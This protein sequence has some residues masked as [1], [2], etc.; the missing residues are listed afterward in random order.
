MLS[1]D[2]VVHFREDLKPVRICHGFDIGPDEERAV[3][4]NTMLYAGAERYFLFQ[5]LRD[6]NNT[7]NRGTHLHPHGTYEQD[8]A[9][10]EIPDFHM[11]ARL[12]PPDLEFDVL[13]VCGRH[14]VS[15][16]Y[17]LFAMVSRSFR[18]PLTVF[19]MSHVFLP[20]SHA[21]YNL[22]SNLDK[23]IK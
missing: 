21:V 20:G 15:F 8:P 3:I 6:G 9:A 18:V 11:L 14:M 13:F 4:F 12:A 7:I 22:V 17:P 10:A 2:K 16:L 1:H 19:P 5:P 23:N